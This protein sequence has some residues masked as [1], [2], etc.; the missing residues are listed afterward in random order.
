MKGQCTGLERSSD[1]AYEMGCFHFIQNL[2]MCQILENGIKILAKSLKH[3]IYVVH[4]KMQK[5]MKFTFL[6]GG[7]Q[8]ARC[9]AFHLVYQGD[10]R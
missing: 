1:L 7:N 6:K 10:L 5:P 2:F 3:S 9:E 8:R 4:V